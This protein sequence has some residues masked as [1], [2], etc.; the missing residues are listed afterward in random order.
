MP[1]R[2][3][4]KEVKAYL[5]PYVIEWYME[6]G[7]GQSFTEALNNL[8]KKM[9]CTPKEGD[10]PKEDKPCSEISLSSKKLTTCLGATA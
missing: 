1:D 9:G 3:K 5:Y 2:H 10:V 6:Q 7:G 8:A 4:K